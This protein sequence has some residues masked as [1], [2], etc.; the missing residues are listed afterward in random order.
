[1]RAY[2]AETIANDAGLLALGLP[3]NAVYSAE[4][5]DTPSAKPFIVLRWLERDSELAPHRNAP[6]QINTLDIWCYDARGD[7]TRIDAMLARLKALLS[8]IKAQQTETGWITCVDWYGDGRD[9]Y[10]DVWEAIVRTST[11]RIVASYTVAV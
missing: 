6:S 5:V 7:Y 11:Y 8:V 2:I 3:A 9:A 10:D 1:M 4:N